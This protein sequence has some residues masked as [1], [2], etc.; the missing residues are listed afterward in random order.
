MPQLANDQSATGSEFTQSSGL[1]LLGRYMLPDKREF[2]CIV[3]HVALSSVS[4]KS[5]ELGSIG[6]HVIVYIDQLGRVEG[7]IGELFDDGFVFNIKM[8]PAARNRWADRIASIDQSSHMSGSEQRGDVRVEPEQASS[9]FTLPDGRVYPCKVI[10]MSISG[11]SI[12][13]DVFPSIGT[14]VQLGK[15]SGKVV[16]HHGE[17]VAIEFDNVPETGTLADRFSGI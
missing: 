9:R 7:E 1:N 6:D 13:I 17:G 4:L 8:A 14:P 5:D 2:E 11:A 12:K 3:T 16:R 15:M 10:D